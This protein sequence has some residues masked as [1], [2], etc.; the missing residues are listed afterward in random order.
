MKKSIFICFLV[1][2][3]TFSA[4]KSGNP[5]YSIQ[6]RRSI[7]TTQPMKVVKDEAEAFLTI[8]EKELA[9]WQFFSKLQSLPKL[10]SEPE[11]NSM[12]TTDMNSASIKK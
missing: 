2:T 1:P 11:G 5:G 7:P 10:P 4:G 3:I 9:A 6:Y 8:N 12:D